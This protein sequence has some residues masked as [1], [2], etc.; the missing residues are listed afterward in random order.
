[1]KSVKRKCTVPLIF[2]STVHYHYAI[3]NNTISLKI[4]VTF[5]TLLL[6]LLV[7]YLSVTI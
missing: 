4:T 3:H 5:V 1:M 7:A 6:P 2:K